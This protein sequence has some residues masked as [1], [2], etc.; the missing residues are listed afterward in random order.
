MVQFSQL[1]N[2]GNPDAVFEEVKSLFLYFYP[3]EEFELVRTVFKDLHELFSGNYHGYRAC[4]TTYHNILHTTDAMLAFSRLIDGYN[5]SSKIILPIEKVR[6]GLI[7]VILHDSGYIQSEEDAGGTGAKYTLSHVKRSISFIK[8]YFKKIG[9]DNRSFLSAGTMV[10]CTGLQVNVSGMSFQDK[11]DRILGFMLGTADLIGQMASRTYLER[12][13]YLYNEFKEGDVPGYESEFDLLKKTV[14]FYQNIV[15]PRLEQDFEGMYKLTRMHFK[16]R[17]DVDKDLYSEA[18]KNNME[19]L[20]KV[21]II[22][23]DKYYSKLRRKIPGSEQ[24]DT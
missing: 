19:Y 17:Y 1:V 24:T 4:N 11:H 21:I 10:E 9:L 14:D 23:P 15:V 8:D 7:A 5:I 20:E 6:T 22:S 18:I 3:E 12:L 2:M 16:K 13:I